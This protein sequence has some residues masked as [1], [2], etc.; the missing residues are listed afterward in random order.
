MGGLPATATHQATHAHSPTRINPYAHQPSAA[1]SPNQYPRYLPPESNVYQHPG[2]H[3][4]ESGEHVG[5]HTGDFGTNNSSYSSHADPYH[6]YH[7]QLRQNSHTHVLSRSMDHAQPQ[8][9]T[10]LAHSIHEVSGLAAAEAAA[11]AAYAYH[12]YHQQQ[13]QAHRHGLA[14]Q[15]SSTHAHYQSLLNSNPR[16]GYYHGQ[17]EE[18]FSPRDLA[19][20]TAHSER[21]DPKS[22]Y[23]AETYRGSQGAPGRFL[24]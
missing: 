14:V 10:H 13:Q 1:F 17:L 18:H 20:Y 19:L 15:A 3:S 9:A 21:R 16:G 24:F 2:A 8:T 7:Q 6:F 12:Q 11:A 23:L 22:A 5:F 4:A